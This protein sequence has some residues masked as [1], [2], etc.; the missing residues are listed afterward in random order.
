VRDPC[1]SVR[2]P[3]KK[4]GAGFS[5]RQQE[6]TP[7]C[8]NTGLHGVLRRTQALLR[9]GTAFGRGGMRH[10]VTGPSRRM[11]GNVA[12]RGAGQATTGFGREAPFQEHVRDSLTE[13]SI[14][15]KQKSPCSLI[16]S[17]YRRQLSTARAFSGR[18]GLPLNPTQ[19]PDQ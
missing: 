14:H 19:I 10:R 8:R 1:K 4:I 13:S 5:F 2:P 6:T 11:T 7:A 9:A 12:P 15:K 17:A 3:A 18:F 16:L